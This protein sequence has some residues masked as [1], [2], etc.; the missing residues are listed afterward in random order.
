MFVANS[1]HCTDSTT[2]FLHCLTIQCTPSV[3]IYLLS[4][5]LLPRRLLSNA[6]PSIKTIWYLLI[7]SQICI[8]FFLPSSP[9]YKQPDPRIH[10]LH[11]SKCPAR[12][13]ELFVFSFPAHLF[14]R[15][16]Q[17]LLLCTTR[18]SPALPIHWTNPSSER[19]RI[20]FVQ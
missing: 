13:P 17:H 9:F 14:S 11:Y 12:A 8:I 3:I 1:S 15:H 10:Q 19:A 4:H 2:V 7:H 5:S 6:V 20:Y 16:T 18:H